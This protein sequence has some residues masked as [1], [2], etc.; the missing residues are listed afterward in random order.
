ML[1]DLRIRSGASIGD[2]DVDAAEFCNSVSDEPVQLV[3]VRDVTVTRRDSAPQVMFQAFES[4]GV[5][6]SREDPRSLCDEAFRDRSADARGR[7][8]DEGDSALEAMRDRSR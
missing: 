3:L 2:D 4:M 6:V 7:A 1:T 5:D 8:G